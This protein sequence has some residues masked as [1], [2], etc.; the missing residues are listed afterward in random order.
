MK[1]AKQILKDRS[2]VAMIA[3]M[4]VI[5]IVILLAAAMF[6]ISSSELK[7][8]TKNETYE[9]ASYLA[10]SGVEAVV[11]AFDKLDDTTKNKMQP[12]GSAAKDVITTD[13][14]WLCE[15]GKTIVCQAAAPAGALGQ[16]SGEV[17]VISQPD[18]KGEEQEY[19][20]FQCVATIDG[21]SATKTAVY[22][23]RETYTANTYGWY[24]TKDGSL[25]KGKQSSD[26]GTA[27]TDTFPGA[28]SLGG[29]NSTQWTVAELNGGENVI[30]TGDESVSLNFGS[31]NN[32]QMIQW[33]AD[34]IIFNLPVDLSLSQSGGGTNKVQVLCLKSK[35]VLFR[36][37]VTLYA[38]ASTSSTNL[39]TILFVAKDATDSAYSIVFEKGLFLKLESGGSTV[40]LQLVAPGKAYKFDDTHNTSMSGIDLMRYFVQ[41][42]N[43]SPK[44]FSS[45]TELTQIVT[46]ASDGTPKN[47]YNY[48]GYQKQTAAVSGGYQVW[49]GSWSTVY[50]TGTRY[51]FKNSAY[52]GSQPTT[53]TIYSSKNTRNPIEGSWSKES[54]GYWWFFP[55]DGASR[56]GSYVY[57][58]S[59][60]WWNPIS[61]SWKKV[62]SQ[63]VDHYE[64]K[65]ASGT[66]TSTSDL[67]YYSSYYGYR[68]IT[69]AIQA[70]V[71]GGTLSTKSN[72]LY[73]ET[74]YKYVPGS[75]ATSEWVAPTAPPFTYYH[76]G[77]DVG[78]ELE[79][80]E[81]VSKLIDGILY[82]EKDTVYEGLI[83]R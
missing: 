46:V 70:T 67:Y 73:N 52:G 37:K 69:N 16:A 6:H 81:D 18:D 56:T 23:R 19:Y 80:I 15:D 43:N 36:E 38:S 3:A 10:R 11:S 30:M 29:G 58:K 53:S 12:G 62:T 24:D 79:N 9:K 1:R 41:Q 14:L 54:D 59:G 75:D 13:P 64:W 82:Q 5:V 4:G 34:K 49:D 78:Q 61:G 57:Y 2:G 72:S 44:S 83:W 35:A 45:S 32:N 17:R 27:F 48:N 60:S 77:G 47:P 25:N 63:T 50:N 74:L 28:G 51:G 40:T 76:A 33:S 31:G 65:P 22:A 7:L 68:G 66:L 21:T 42:S 8:T 71:S 55:D 20:Q 26:A 39:A